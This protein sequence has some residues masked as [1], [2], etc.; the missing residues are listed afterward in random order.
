M[1]RTKQD[2]IKDNWHQISTT[3][4]GLEIWYKE[5][6]FDNNIQYIR[7]N[8]NT[9]EDCGLEVVNFEQLELLNKIYEAVISKRYSI[10][11]G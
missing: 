6:G 2:L 4:N 7:W 9:K 11:E 1:K 10:I 5:T 3:R 8:P